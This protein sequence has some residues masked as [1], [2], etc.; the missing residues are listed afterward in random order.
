VECPRGG[1]AGQRARARYLLAYILRR[2]LWRV[3]GFFTTV[4]LG[5]AGNVV[6]T[7]AQLDRAKSLRG[8]LRRHA[9]RIRAR[10]NALGTPWKFLC[11]A[12][13]IGAQLAL[14][15][16][17][18]E[19]VVLIPIGFMIPLVASGSRRSYA[20]V[21][22][23]IFAATYKRYFGATHRAA[24]RR[25]RTVR[26]LQALRGGMRLLRM[27]YLAAWRLWKYDPRYRDP[28]GELWVSVFEPIRLWRARKLDGYIGRPL[29]GRRCAPGS[30][31]SSHGANL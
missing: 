27:R 3:A 16:V 31:K 10:W 12:A 9:G 5:Y 8:S 14:F 2:R 18:S 15:P 4:G 6:L 17:L 26:I 20:W 11:V 25:L 7:H 13:A 24:A 22:D 1:A 21:A 28:S 19:Y 23:S 29:L 30:G